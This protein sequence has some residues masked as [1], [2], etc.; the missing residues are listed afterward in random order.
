ML[1]KKNKIKFLSLQDKDYPSALRYIADPPYVLYVKGEIKKED[2]LSIGVVG[3]R[4]PTIYG[5]SNTEKIVNA[6]L[7]AGFSIISGLARG[8]YTIAHRAAVE[9]KRRT[10][11]VL[12]SG[13]LNVYPSENESLV[14]E[15][16]ENGAVVSEFPLMMKPEKYN[17]PR[18]N[19]IIS[20][21]SL[22]TLV[23][24]A[25]EVS[26]ALITARYALEQGREVFA[27]PGNIDSIMSKGTNS[28]IKQGAKL[29][30]NYLDIIEELKGVLPEEFL[31]RKGQSELM[32]VALTEIESKLFNTLGEAPKHIDELVKESGVAVN[33]VLSTLV[34]LE[35][36]GLAKQYPGKNFLKA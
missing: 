18:R 32:A 27:V 6:L 30:E 7:D 5:R 26:G 16:I 1:L 11:A 8:V 14:W 24:E 33:A 31:N 22:G 35:I 19:R 3:C 4:K 34:N 21:L 23:V 10:V 29:V 12:G 15:I 28:L 17:F 9:K 2:Q 25:G 20:G 36:K 13:L